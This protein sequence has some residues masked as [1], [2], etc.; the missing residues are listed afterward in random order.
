MDNYEILFEEKLELFAKL[1]EEGA[2][3]WKGTSA[4]GADEPARVSAGRA[5]ADS[6]L[7]RGGRESR[8]RGAR[9]A[10]RAA[11]DARDNRRECVAIRAVTR[12]YRQLCDELGKGVLPVAVHSPGHVAETDAKA[13]EEFWTA[14]KAMRDRIG[15]ERGWPPLTRREFEA[16][17]ESGA[18]Y[19]GSPETVARKITATVQE[20][21]LDRFDFKYSAGT[22]SARGDGAEH[23]VV[24][25][26]GGTAGEEV[27][28][29]G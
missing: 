9:G 29:D 17:V 5:C 13:R 16:E 26:G 11:A 10:L 12:L 21:G 1:R 28:R 8:V 15:A 23:R 25:R 4:L 2:V 22:L 14:F 3:T 7:D 20:L 27:T 19:V 6:H 18:L 24:R